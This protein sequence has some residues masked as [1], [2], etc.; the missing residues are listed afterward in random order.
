MIIRRP[1]TL[2]MKILKRT[3][4]SEHMGTI[5]NQE[6]L[7]TDS[8]EGRKALQRDLDRPESWEVTNHMK[9]NKSKCWILQL[10]WGYPG[11]T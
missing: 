9:F 6:E 10:G 5:L 1:L 8:L 11:Y 3:W 7:W 4:Q 2:K